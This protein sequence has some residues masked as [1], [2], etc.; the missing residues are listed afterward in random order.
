MITKEQLQKQVE[1][2]KEIPVKGLIMGLKKKA[3]D[4]N[5][6]GIFIGETLTKEQAK[7]ANDIYVISIPKDNHLGIEVGEIIR[8]TSILPEDSIDSTVPGYEVV[9]VRDHMV[10]TH[11][12]FECVSCDTKCEGC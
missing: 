2:T 5:D 8:A 9:L 10:L 11:K 4:T 3:K 12:P 6:D 7:K 1:V